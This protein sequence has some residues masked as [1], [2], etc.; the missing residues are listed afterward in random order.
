M[1]P[2]IDAQHM[3]LFEHIELLGTMHGDVSRIPKTLDFLETYTAEHL[4]D[5]QSL[6]EQSRY[7]RALEHRRQHQDFIGKLKKLRE[8]YNASGHT[9]A[10]LM[11]MNHA[12]VEWLK[13]HILQSDKQ[14]AT[15]Y[16]ALPEERQ[17]SLRLP[18]RPW[19][20]ESSQS[21]YQDVTGIRPKPAAEGAGGSK[22]TKSV[23]GSSWTDAMLCGIP[24]IDEQHQELFR[25]ID[26]LRDRGNADRVP[27]V[28]RFLA[29][30]VVKHF[31]DEESLHLRSRYPRASEHRK[32]HEH[33]VKTFWELKAKYDSSTGDFASVMA[34]TG[35]VFDWL[36]NHVLKVD[37]EFAKYYL[38]LP[39]ADSKSPL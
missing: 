33:F 25:Q 7:P 19:I 35:V 14:F 29:D 17:L 12:I 37:K 31:N 34:V 16:H 32:A 28:L 10:T 38:A 3:A 36:K 2:H 8:D 27:G 6:H 9:L 23:L 30:Y 15:F 39:E 4:A 18:L 26:I 20:P 21:F 1:I 11:D 22:G 24:L 13:N 5:E